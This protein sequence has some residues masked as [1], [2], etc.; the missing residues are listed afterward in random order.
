MK[1]TGLMFGNAGTPTSKMIKKRKMDKTKTIFE[2]VP[3]LEPSIKEKIEKIFL[4]ALPAEVE[5]DFMQI[6]KEDQIL[7][8]PEAD[9]YVVFPFQTKDWVLEDQW[10]FSL[11][12]HNKPV[13]ITTLP[14][15]E[16][17]SYGN[18]FYPYFMRDSREID[19]LLNLSHEVYL[20]K[21]ENDLATTLK[22]LHV[23]NK[24]RNTKVLC[25]GTPMYEPFHSKDWGYEMVRA[26]QERFGVQW[27][28]IS[29]DKF[30]KYW[31]D[32]DEEIDI[33]DI[34][35]S[36]R[37]IYYVKEEWLKGIKKAYLVI[38]KMLKEYGAN[39]M[40]INCINYVN[41]ILY[42]LHMTPC[43]ALS[44]LNNEGIPAICE[45][46]TTTTID[47]LI[48]S[49]STNSPG[50]M[51]NPYLFPKDNRILCS[52]CTSP[53]VH[54]YENPQ[55][56]DFDLY[57]YFEF[58]TLPAG[59]TVSKKPERITITAISESS[60]DKMLVMNAKIER[61]TYFPTCRTQVVMKM[62]KDVKEIAKHYEGRHWIYV[63]GD[64]A[65]TVKKVNKILGI[66][67]I[68]L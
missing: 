12:S 27:L 57:P 64:H 9:V 37:K 13:V 6:E 68:S 54:S 43:Y 23:R 42:K 32:F 40:T 4:D 20:I 59:I 48:T 30:L 11:Y 7:D 66:E 5:H 55:K 49:Y 2:K 52:H 10:F 1:I 3:E 51:V 33:S 38:R 14:F 17:F 36:V 18:V 63:Y 67:T 44:R 25:I 50:S 62:D 21:D 34:K 39:A 22:A 24:I 53:T 65:E 31:E 41:S 29:P 56:D 19:K 16:V 45:A 46:D 8:L 26:V 58:P 60:L 28:Y 15:S 47:M 35:N 61:N